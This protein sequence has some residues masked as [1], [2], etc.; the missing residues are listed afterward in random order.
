[1]FIPL[2][3]TLIECLQDPEE[4]GVSGITEEII[5]NTF[6]YGDDAMVNAWCEN[7]AVLVSLGK[8]EIRVV[9][10]KSTEIPLVVCEWLWFLIAKG[11]GGIAA[12]RAALMADF[13]KYAIEAAVL[14]TT[15]PYYLTDDFIAIKG[16]RELIDRGEVSASKAVCSV[17]LNM[18][19]CGCRPY[20]AFGEQTTYGAEFVK[21]FKSIFKDVLV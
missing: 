17:D 5:R 16:L 21:S 10:E 12:E 15:N 6:E 4:C 13:F 19:A 1:M 14:K 8:G 2:I 18:L 3:S 9:R 11:A 7:I 20:E